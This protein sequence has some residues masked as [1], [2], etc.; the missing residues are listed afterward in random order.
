MAMSKGQC[1]KT[2]ILPCIF[3][4]LSPLNHYFFIV[5]ACLGHI[6]ESTKQLYET[7]FIDERKCIV[8]KNSDAILHFTGVISPYYFS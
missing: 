8:Q 2:I 7:W 1:P 4:E 3:I 6:L 5:D